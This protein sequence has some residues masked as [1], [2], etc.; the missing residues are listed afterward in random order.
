MKGPT[1]ARVF[2][3]V[4]V[5]GSARLEML[6]PMTETEKTLLA[7]DTL[8]SLPRK[9]AVCENTELLTTTSLSKLSKRVFGRTHASSDGFPKLMVW[10][11]LGTAEGS[12]RLISKSKLSVLSLRVSPVGRL[13]V[14]AI[15]SNEDTILHVRKKAVCN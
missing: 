6:C 5:T 4:R 9:T 2:S 13:T 7:K 14:A 8:V 10:P 15:S 11:S 1:L 3:N 12:T